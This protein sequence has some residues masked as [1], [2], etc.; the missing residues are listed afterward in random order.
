MGFQVVKTAMIECSKSFP[1][2]V[3]GT[4]LVIRPL[5]TAGGL[6]AATVMD[7]APMMNIASFGMCSAKANP[8][9]IAATAAA[10]GASVPGACIPMI[11]GPWSPGAK[12]V[13]VMKLAA[14]D[15]A[16]TCKCAYDGA[17]IKVVSAGQTIVKVK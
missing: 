7:F 12:K 15:D 13:K 10:M 6:D 14:L 9:V 3:P 11:T 16:S 8:T 4:L 2:K 1:P 5:V 17:T